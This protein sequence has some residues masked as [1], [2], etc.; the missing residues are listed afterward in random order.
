MIAGVNQRGLLRIASEA[1]V[2]TV[3]TQG[4]QTIG[5]IRRVVGRTPLRGALELAHGLVRQDF[6]GDIDI[7]PR[8]DLR[9]YPKLLTNPSREDLAYF[10]Q[11][12]ERGT[13]PKLALIRDAT[14]ISRCLG[15][16][17]RALKARLAGPADT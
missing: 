12:G 3:K 1:A 10:V 9:A 6:Q 17:E 7:H 2:S 16:C 14:R 5:L 13:W 4:L 15:R 8:F 11:E